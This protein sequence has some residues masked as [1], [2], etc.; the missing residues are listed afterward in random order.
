M[1]YDEMDHLGA[2]ISQ[3]RVERRIQ[4][5]M[6][7][8]K[9]D[10]VW[11]EGMDEIIGKYF[12]DPDWPETEIPAQTYPKKTQEL[13]NALERSHF[14]RWVEA[15]NFIR[16]LSG[17]GRSQFE[18]HFNAAFPI[19]RERP[20]TFFAHGGEVVAMFGLM[21]SDTLEL[22]EVLMKKAEAFALAF[23]TNK[24]R[25]FQLGVRPNREIL[26][27]R[28]VWVSAP[29]AIRNDY[30]TIVEDAERLRGKIRKI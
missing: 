29:A 22:R 12:A 3:N 20:T 11:M 26:S 2:Y 16:D 6:L 4:Q 7:D 17:D 18:D 8:D 28:M 30:G 10:A 24:I 15:D 14:P 9:V 25:L 27:A 13:L 19:L 5:M 21:R 1:L 23:E